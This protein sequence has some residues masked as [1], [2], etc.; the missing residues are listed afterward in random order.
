MNIEYS[1]RQVH[2]MSLFVTL[3]SMLQSAGAASMAAV[4][5]SI[6]WSRSGATGAPRA[7]LILERHVVTSYVSACSLSHSS[8]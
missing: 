7:L 6:L 2:F 5:L 4:L 8:G 1:N 3:A